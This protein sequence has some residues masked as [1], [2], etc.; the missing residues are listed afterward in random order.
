[1]KK[2]R[3]LIELSYDADLWH[4]GSKDKV[5]RSWFYNEILA[6]KC[7]KDDLVLHS[8]DTDTIGT[9]RILKYVN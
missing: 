7:G 5:A 9:V 6:G 2:I 3:M 8:N 1:M 4:S